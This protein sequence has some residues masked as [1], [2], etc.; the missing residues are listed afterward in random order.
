MTP[1]M[2]YKYQEQIDKLA[3]CGVE[4]PEVEPVQEGEY[5]RYAFLNSPEKNH[6]PQYISNPRR[7]L[8]NIDSKSA[9]MTLLALSCFKDAEKAVDYYAELRKNCKQFAK[10][11]GDSLFGGI[12]SSNDGDV[13]PAN[14]MTHFNLFESTQ[15]DLNRTF[16]FKRPLI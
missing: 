13:T 1:I 4:M 3:E 16:T 6:I 5:Y 12:I 8:S 10:T 11:A 15:C 9:R 7:M 2:A 14:E